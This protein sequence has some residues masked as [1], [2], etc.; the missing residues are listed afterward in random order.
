MSRQAVALQPTPPR[1]PTLS[2]FSHTPSRCFA[3]KSRCGGRAAAP[4]TRRF[5]SPCFTHTPL[6]CV[7]TN[8]PAHEDLRSTADCAGSGP[9]ID[10]RRQG[11]APD[12]WCISRQ[13]GAMLWCLAMSDPLL[14]RNTPDWP[15]S[16]PRSSRAP[17]LLPGLC[18]RIYCGRRVV[19]HRRR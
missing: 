6:R 10:G 3:T 1:R 18:L 7:A 17:R 2:N 9:G 15:C 14:T 19:D 5:T 16:R 13:P 8:I 11:R 12:L 4:P